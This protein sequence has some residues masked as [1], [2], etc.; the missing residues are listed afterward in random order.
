MHFQAQN[1]R[2]E[3]I[4]GIL[5]E[6]HTFTPFLKI[7]KGFSGG[8]D[9]RLGIAKHRSTLSDL[10][11][12]SFLRSGLP[13]FRAS[14]TPQ[15]LSVTRTS[16]LNRGRPGKCAIDSVEALVASALAVQIPSS[17]AES[18]TNEAQDKSQTAL[19]RFSGRAP[20]RPQFFSIASASSS[21]TQTFSAVPSRDSE[22]HRQ[23]GTWSG[24][25]MSATTWSGDP[26]PLRQDPSACMFTLDAKAWQ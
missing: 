12:P 22:E 7:N 16:L 15:P 18:G 23:K 11:G 10:N 19:V 26:C 24:K 5:T 9:V 2:K 8:S 13:S 17:M 21:P 3:R 4:C 20:E 1:L 14:R 6:E 25:C